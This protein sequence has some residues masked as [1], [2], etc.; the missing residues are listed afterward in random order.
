MCSHSSLANSW[1]TTIFLVYNLLFVEYIM[2]FYLISV[3]SDVLIVI[4][5]HE[6]CSHLLLFN[7]WQNDTFLIYNLLFV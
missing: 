4:F 7:L 1:Q 6:T 5:F 3:I 2:I